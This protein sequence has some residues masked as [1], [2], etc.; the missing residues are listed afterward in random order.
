M[1]EI[2]Y[3]GLPRKAGKSDIGAIMEIAKALR[4]WFTP[5]ARRNMRRSFNK[6]R[7]YVIESGGKP[8]GFILYRQWKRVAIVTW[9][10]VLPG[11]QRKGAGSTLLRAMEAALK[12]SR[13]RV[14]K[15]STLSHTT[16]YV[17]YERTRKF[18][19][20][21]GFRKLRID[22]EYYPDGS[23]RLVLSKNL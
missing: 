22:R 8:V 9:M 1:N 23:D 19:R 7:G 15:V 17:P 5:A 13:V 2:F 3:M 18:Y 14:V 11:E 20:K 4:A 12:K 6:Q 16:P 21:M 10:G